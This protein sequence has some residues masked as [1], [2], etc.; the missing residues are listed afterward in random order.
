MKITEQIYEASWAK[1]YVATKNHRIQLEKDIADANE[2][3]AG[4]GLQVAAAK[5]AADRYDEACKLAVEEWQR[6]LGILD[7]N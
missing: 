5:A 3:P 6:D 2:L 7:D 4:E 1:R